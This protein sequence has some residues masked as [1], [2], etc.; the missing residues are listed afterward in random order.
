MS[1]TGHLGT[2]FRF[3]MPW[4]WFFSRTRCLTRCA[5]RATCRRS[6]G[7]R[8]SGNHTDGKKS[9][10]NSCARIRASTLSVLTFA[11]AIA[12]VLAGFDT[13]TRRALGVSR[14]AIA[15]LFPVASKATS[16]SG[17]SVSAQACSS[18]GDSPTRPSSRTS[19]S[20]TTASWANSRCTSMP[21]HLPTRFSFHVSRQPVRGTNGRNDNYG[22][23][24]SARPGESQGRP[25]TNTGSQPT[26]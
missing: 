9:A 18:F 15:S 14:I 11:S 26:E 25:I 6:I 24:L 16:S 12:R 13:T 4:I 22:Y 20:S 3:K 23:A 1:E 7:V 8:S 21:I 2:R 17:S 19:P 10:A 5:R